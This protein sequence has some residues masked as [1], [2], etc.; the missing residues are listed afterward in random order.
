MYMHDPITDFSIQVYVCHAGTWYKDYNVMFI[1]S[2][3]TSVD[4]SI[5]AVS[6][7]RP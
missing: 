6:S 5:M 3:K 7:E 4:K 1:P 2:P